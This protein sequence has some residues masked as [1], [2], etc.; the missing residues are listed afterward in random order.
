MT[1]KEDINNKLPTI[2]DII[3]KNRTDRE[4]KIIARKMRTDIF[5][6]KLRDF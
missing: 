6:K 2:K 5:L 1:N 3:L 4:I